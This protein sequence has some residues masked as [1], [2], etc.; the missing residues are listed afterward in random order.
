MR[1]LIGGPY[2]A[3]QIF[4]W[5]LLTF[6]VARLTRYAVEDTIFDTPRDWIARKNAWLGELISCPWCAGSWLTAGVYLVATLV[7][8]VDVPLP[9]LQAGAT[10]YVASRVV[11]DE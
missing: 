3:W 1:W 8:H 2:V 9:V 4:Q 5:A 11:A 6:T 7:C 10:L